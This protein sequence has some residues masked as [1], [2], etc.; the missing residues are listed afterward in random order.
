SHHLWGAHRDHALP[1]PGLPPAL[2]LP[3]PT[4]GDGIAGGRLGGRTDIPCA[5][6]NARRSG[7]FWGRQCAAAF[8]GTPASARLRLGDVWGSV[9]LA[10]WNGHPLEAWS[11]SIGATARK[12]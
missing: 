7:P 3:L 8:P 5:T 6:G 9:A 12:P 10:G 4:A 2:F 1:Q 11:L